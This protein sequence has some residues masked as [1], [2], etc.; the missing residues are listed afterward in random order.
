MAILQMITDESSIT[1]TQFSAAATLVSVLAALRSS[2]SAH[3]LPISWGL[4][5][6]ACYHAGKWSRTWGHGH[7]GFCPL[8]RRGRPVHL[9]GRRMTYAEVRRACALT[10]S[11][12]GPTGCLAWTFVRNGGGRRPSLVRPELSWAWPPRTPERPGM[13]IPR[14]HAIL[15]TLSALPVALLSGCASNENG[16]AM[17]DPTSVVTPTGTPLI[18]SPVHRS[19]ISRVQSKRPGRSRLPFPTAGSTLCGGQQGVLGMW[20]YPP[21]CGRQEVHIPL[22]LW[23]WMPTPSS[24]V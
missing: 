15:G 18:P 14:R 19:D 8:L 9:A 11:K 16:A 5:D 21:G 12:E 2:V 17:S 24:G 3:G 6:E 10:D 1:P 7:R 13:T 23:H 4:G 20:V 22:L